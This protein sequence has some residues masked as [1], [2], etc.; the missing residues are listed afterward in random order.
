MSVREVALDFHAGD[1]QVRLIGT[2]HTQLTWSPWKPKHKVVI[3]CLHRLSRTEWLWA[4]F[5]Q[6]AD[7]GLRCFRQMGLHFH[8]VCKSMK[9]CLF[10]FLPF[11]T[12]YFCV[13]SNLWWTGTG[14]NH[15]LP[16]QTTFISRYSFILICSFICRCVNFYWS[17]CWHATMPN[18]LSET[19]CDERPLLFPTRGS[20]TWAF[21]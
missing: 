20:L 19:T 1:R 13:Q 21:S 4:V 10:D 15:H 5:L 2:R 8:I 3:F 9:H 17:T 7:V 11:M 14:F 16:F 12:F 18:L 6:T